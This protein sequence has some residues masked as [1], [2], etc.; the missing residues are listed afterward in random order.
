[1]NKFIGNWRITEMEQWDQD[2]VDLE[3]PGY[4]RFSKD[5]MGKFVFGTVNGFTDCRY[6][7]DQDAKRV[8]FSW[9]G[10]SESDPVCGRGW[11]EMTATDK[12]YGKL[13]IH[14]GDESWVKAVK[15]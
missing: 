6:D 9:D 5:G 8:E 1:M 15:R 12:I 10:A 11:F 3:E 7:N 14:N 13:F 2:Y 4:L